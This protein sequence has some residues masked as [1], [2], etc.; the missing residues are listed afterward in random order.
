MFGRCHA[1]NASGHDGW[2]GT[3]NAQQPFPRFLCLPAQTLVLAT[4]SAND[5]GINPD[6]DRTQPCPIDV[7]VIGDLATDVRIVRP[8]QLLRG[9]AASVPPTYEREVQAMRISHGQ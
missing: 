9:S 5:I 1:I 4:H 8:G 7:A 6:E 3:S 2:P